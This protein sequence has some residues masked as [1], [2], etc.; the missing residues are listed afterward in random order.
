MDSMKKCSWIF[1]DE[2][3]YSSEANIREKVCYEKRPRRV[4]QA[5]E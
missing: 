3:P 5:I 4:K 1:D 2:V